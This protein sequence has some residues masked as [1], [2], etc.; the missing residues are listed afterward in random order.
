MTDNFSSAVLHDGSMA[1]GSGGS[2]LS[3][4]TYLIRVSIAVRS[5]G[6]TVQ[7]HHWDILF[8]LVNDPFFSFVGAGAAS[9]FSIGF[10]FLWLSMVIRVEDM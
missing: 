3:D 9:G 7:R 4:G 5:F 6:E 1:L 10:L 8:F 2:N